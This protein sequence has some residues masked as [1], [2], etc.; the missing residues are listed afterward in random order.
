MATCTDTTPAK[1]GE[2]TRAPKSVSKSQLESAIEDAAAAETLLS[3]V[4]DTILVESSFASKI[5]TSLTQLDGYRIFILT[6]AETEALRMALRVALY[7]AQ[8]ARTAW[9]GYNAAQRKGE[10][11]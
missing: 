1:A 9:E 10:A 3:H 2:G 7:A 8:D 5:K 4:E 6:E 11:A